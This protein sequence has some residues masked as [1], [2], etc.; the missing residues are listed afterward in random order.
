[1][2][3]ALPQR[4]SRLCGA[5]LPDGSVVDID[6]RSDTAGPPIVA[7]VR[8][9]AGSPAA[10]SGTLDLTGYLLLTAPA[11]PHAHLDKALSWDTLAPPFG[12]LGAAIANWRNG[13]RVFTAESFRE[14]ATA[15]ALALVRNGVTAIR[16]HVDILEGP[17]PLRG[18]VAV[19]TVRTRLRGLA[20][21]EI[22]V[23]VP[24]HADTELVHAALDAGADLVG[25][26]PHV[27]PDPVAE[28]IRLLRLAHERDIGADLHI[29][30]FLHGDH[31]T[32][33]TFAEQVEHWPPERPRTAG[34]CC[35]LGTMPENELAELLRAVARS[36]IG[37]V[38][39]PLTNL[40]LQGWDDPVATPRGLTAINAL[41]DAGIPVAA[42]GDNVR[43]PFNPVGRS[44][45]LETAALLIA[46]G[47]VAP[48]TALRLITDGAREVLG[49]PE[50]GA[51]VGARAEFLAVRGDSL[52]DVLAN[53]PA[54]R[55]V[56]HDGAV[57]SISRTEH[58]F[59]EFA[60]VEV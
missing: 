2:D 41:L 30:E 5:R 23:M 13:S 34:H 16:T 15:A 49:L 10:D 18:I 43:D 9:A 20:D 4:I 33:A 11:E 52:L 54:D 48:E 14:R 28:T 25:G 29:D 19:D 53:A 47:H 58:R 35:R 45:P 6:I 40:Y 42:G 26:A 36:G 21:L 1:M 32:F 56:I 46:A 59:A 22:V 44:D 50:A 24:S 39:L 17:D 55:I 12:D 51:K 8:P 27:A 31:H 37:V 60:A 7:A 57:V 38:S 3:H